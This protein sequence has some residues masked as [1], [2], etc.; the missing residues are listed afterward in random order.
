MLNP[1]K[2]PD[3]AED[4]G[5]PARV[6]IHVA[7]LSRHLPAS[8]PQQPLAS[9]VKGIHIIMIILCSDHHLPCFGGQKLFSLQKGATE[10]P[11][12]KHVND[13]NMESVG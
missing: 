10:R 3:T 4:L 12:P 7:S 6:P 11:N 2:S 1:P 9:T 8:S 5:H 13:V